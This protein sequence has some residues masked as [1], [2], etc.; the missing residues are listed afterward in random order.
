MHT[1]KEGRPRGQA[2]GALHPYTEQAAAF[3]A[4]RTL[5]HNGGNINSRWGVSRGHR[6]TSRDRS[7]LKVGGLATFALVV[8]AALYLICHVIAQRW[9]WQDA[10]MAMLAGWVCWIVGSAIASAT[11]R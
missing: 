6:R 4:S 5:G 1:R 10:A 11:G 7:R 8:F 3:A 9:G 2:E